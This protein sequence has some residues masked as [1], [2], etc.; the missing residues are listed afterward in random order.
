MSRVAVVA[1]ALFRHVV[2]AQNAGPQS[3]NGPQ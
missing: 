2:I 1:I 3:F